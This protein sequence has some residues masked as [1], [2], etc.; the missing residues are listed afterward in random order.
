MRRNRDCLRKAFKVK[1]MPRI[2]GELKKNP[3]EESVSSR[4]ESAVWKTSYSL[5]V[6]S[7]LG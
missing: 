7:F 2:E 6:V 1:R 3:R 5:F 4:R